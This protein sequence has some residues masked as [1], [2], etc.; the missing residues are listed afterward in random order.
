[1]DF[2]GAQV[3]EL[4]NLEAVIQ[5]QKRAKQ[6][7]LDQQPFGARGVIE[8]FLSVCNLEDPEMID[9]LR[10]ILDERGLLEMF[11]RNPKK[12]VEEARRV[13]NEIAL[14]RFEERVLADHD[15]MPSIAEIDQFGGYEFETFLKICL[16]EWAI[17]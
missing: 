17:P 13:S 5:R 4:I 3:A 8:A 14:R 6:R 10:E 2:S 15:P 12:V 1:M 16:A 7:I 9:V 11:G